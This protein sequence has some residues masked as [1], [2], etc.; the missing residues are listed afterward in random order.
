[1]LADRW[2]LSTFAPR[3]AAAL[4]AALAVQSA[5]EVVDLA[6]AGGGSGL[7]ALLRYPL[8]LPLGLVLVS[9]VAMLLGG[10]WTALHLVRTGQLVGLEAAGR[11]PRRG[12]LVPLAAAG[13]LWAGLAWL[14]ASEVA[15]RGLAAWS[16]P[17][18]AVDWP[19]W[20][21]GGDRVLYRLGRPDG[22][23]G[24]E[25]VLALEL[26]DGAAASRIEADRVRPGAGG[27]WELLGAST[28]EPGRPVR[29]D[30]RL[31]APGPVPAPGSTAPPQ[32]LA[33]RDLRRAIGAAASVGS[34]PAPLEAERGLRT[35]LA[36]ACPVCLVLGALAGVV[37]GRRPGLAAAAATAAGL[38]YFA[39]L[40]PLWAMSTAGVVSG[41]VVAW[42]PAGAGG[43]VAAALWARGPRRI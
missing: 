13:L 11:G 28:I 6:N 20:V 14:V 26:R 8:R 36:A 43:A 38:L 42:V 23:G 35:A 17:G 22:H 33:G 15:P 16:G 1:M 9:P 25:D 3:F 41:G 21:R 27:A 24:Y 32:Q 29:R 7:D 37:F 31:V 10:C 40:S 30:A 39:I 12:V 19:R 2:V 4:L 34:D 18:A 5:V